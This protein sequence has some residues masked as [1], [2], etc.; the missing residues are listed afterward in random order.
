MINQYPGSKN[1]RIFRI[2]P[3]QLH[4]AAKLAAV[5]WLLFSFA[6]QRAFV[7]YGEASSALVFS[8]LTLV[9]V[10]RDSGS[11]LDGAS[12]RRRLSQLRFSLLLG[13]G[14][15]TAIFSLINSLIL[16][17]PLPIHESKQRVELHTA[18]RSASDRVFHR[19][20]SV[21]G[22]YQL[23]PSALVTS[24]AS[25]RIRLSDSIRVTLLHPSGNRSGF[26][27]LNGLVVVVAR[28]G[29]ALRLGVFARDRRPHRGHSVPPWD[30]KAQPWLYLERTEHREKKVQ[31]ARPI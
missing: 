12:S 13:I 10:M 23:F 14:A 9:A 1:G 27:R 25:L 5:P 20:G 7:D 16:R 24:R 30:F 15:K 21:S 22:R 8:R 26:K 2:P 11:F 17:V 6:S 18:L 3:L 19:S 28:F 29:S 4:L 31:G